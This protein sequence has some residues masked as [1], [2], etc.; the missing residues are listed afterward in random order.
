MELSELAKFPVTLSLN[1]NH[2]KLPNNLIKLVDNSEETSRGLQGREV[3]PEMPNPKKVFQ[4]SKYE[5]KRGN[6]RKIIVFWKH[7]RI[8]HATNI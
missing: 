1:P 2:Q 6:Y 5:S 8:F 3:S 4:I 7:H